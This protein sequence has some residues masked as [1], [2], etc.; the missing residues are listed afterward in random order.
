MSKLPVWARKP[1]HKKTVIATDRG[2]TVK[3]TGEVLRLVSDLPSKLKQLFDEVRDIEASVETEQ[4]ADPVETFDPASDIKSDV[5]ASE[6]VSNT[7][8]KLDEQADASD[9]KNEEMKTETVTQK[10][11]PQ[12][13]TKATGKKKS[14]Y[15]RKKEREQQQKSAE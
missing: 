5:E 1:E 6:T 11:T 10:K 4:Q 15:Q 3:E 13:S 12:K 7:E 8:E 2:W 9:E 14:Y